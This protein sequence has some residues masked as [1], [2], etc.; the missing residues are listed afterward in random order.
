M[1]DLMNNT[2]D[3]LTAIDLNSDGSIGAAR[4]LGGTYFFDRNL[5][6]QGTASTGLAEGAGLALLTMP[7]GKTFAFLG[8]GQSSV[9]VVE[10]G[11]FRAVGDIAIR[12]PIIGPLRVGP[13]RSAGFGA[14]VY[15]IIAGG[16]VV[17]EIPTAMLQ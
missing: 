3:R 4:G 9:Q 16:V 2:S 6:L 11:H 12:H 8:T 7:N 15:A 14:T 17:L 13:G 1:A 10:T 5:R